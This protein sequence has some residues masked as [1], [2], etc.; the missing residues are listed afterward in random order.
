MDVN[1]WT[2]TQ[3]DY[4]RA[5]DGLTPPPESMWQITLRQ[6]GREESAEKLPGKPDTRLRDTS[7]VAEPCRA[8]QTRKAASEHQADGGK[9]LGAQIA[10]NHRMPRV[11]R[12]LIA[13][14]ERTWRWTPRQTR[15]G[16]C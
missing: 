6:G 14:G 10:E 2:W 11:C 13:A 1:R 4:P 16:F 9:Y 3:H 5:E 12:P 7:A 8:G 15:P